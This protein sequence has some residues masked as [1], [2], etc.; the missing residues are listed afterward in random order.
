M[1]VWPPSL[2]TGLLQCLPT[3]APFFPPHA[4]WQP[5]LVWSLESGWRGPCCAA[6]RS[7][8]SSTG[9]SPMASHFHS[10]SKPKS[11]N[12]FKYSVFCPP[13]T[14]YFA[15]LIPSW[16]FLLFINSL[17]IC[18]PLGPCACSSLC[19]KFSFHRCFLY[20]FPL[21]LLTGH[22]N[23]EA[24]SGHFIWSPGLLLHN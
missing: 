5:P 16:V 12:W 6:V 4:H 11:L 19:L 10:E 2:P 13:P 23:S 22:H 15:S 20:S 7:C 8:H 14:P 1:L 18:L 9:T 17:S 24:S 21:S 3:R